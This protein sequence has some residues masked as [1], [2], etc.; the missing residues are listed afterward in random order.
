MYDECMDRTYSARDRA[1]EA[2]VLLEISGLQGRFKRRLVGQPFTLDIRICHRGIIE[3]RQREH[4]EASYVYTWF[5][6]VPGSDARE[7]RYLHPSISSPKIFS[8]FAW[9]KSV[10]SAAL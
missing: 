3:V 7:G 4:D 6:V 9:M 1:C 5:G 10:G 2:S 8:I